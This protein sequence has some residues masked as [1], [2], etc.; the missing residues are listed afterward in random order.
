MRVGN[1]KENIEE[2]VLFE[3]QGKSGN[4]MILESG[5]S[6]NTQGKVRESRGL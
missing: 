5:E 4:P 2:E 3:C 6:Q 1:L